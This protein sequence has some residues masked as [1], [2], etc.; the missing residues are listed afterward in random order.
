MKKE[1]WEITWNFI[2]HQTEFLV[3]S[4]K[5]SSGKCNLNFFELSSDV[6]VVNQG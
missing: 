4:F 5:P 2:T 6:R 3:T 1:K